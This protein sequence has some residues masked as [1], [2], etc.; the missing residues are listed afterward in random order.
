M[1]P[2]LFV[3]S[4]TGTSVHVSLFEYEIAKRQERLA[5]RCLALQARGVAITPIPISVRHKTSSSLHL[6][7]RA[8]HTIFVKLGR[9][10]RPHDRTTNNSTQHILSFSLLTNTFELFSNQET[11]ID[12]LHLSSVEPQRDICQIFLILSVSQALPVFR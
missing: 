6:D 1:K 9:W 10:L 4:S 12:D 8:F 3:F 2:S 5:A 11:I 7:S